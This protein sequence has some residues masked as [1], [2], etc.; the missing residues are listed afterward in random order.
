MRKLVLVNENYLDL[1]PRRDD[2]LDR[3]GVTVQNEGDLAGL[4]VNSV[5][6]SSNVRRRLA[7]GS[8]V[9]VRVTIFKHE[10]YALSR[11]R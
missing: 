7:H 3:M 6:G 1:L 11:F 9:S 4:A 10:N 2:V 8:F 5:D